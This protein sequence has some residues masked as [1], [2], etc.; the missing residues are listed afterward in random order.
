MYFIEV[1]YSVVSTVFHIR[2]VLTELLHHPI[3]SFDTE[4]AGVYS[5]VERKSATKVL[6]QPDLPLETRRSAL[7]VAGNS[8]LSF[9]ALVSVTHFIFGVSEDESVVIICESPVIEKYIWEW[10][11]DYSGKL[12]IHNAL[13][14]LKIMYNR[15][16]ALPKNY[17]DTSLLSKCLINNSDPWLARVGLKELMGSYY[18]PKW[19]LMDTYEPDNLRDP[20]F[21]L[22]AATDGAATFKLWYDIQGYL[23]R[24]KDEQTSL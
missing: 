22:Y 6:A 11:K 24:Q 1:N 2:S 14:D 5:K 20:D 3:L 21:L 17:E 23:E 16:K 12:L 19:S 15:L 13:F 4:T 18:D 8:G 9:P 10:V 7:L